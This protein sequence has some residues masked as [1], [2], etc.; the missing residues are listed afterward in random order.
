M[1]GPTA[2][3]VS[4][5]RPSIPCGVRSCQSRSAKLPQ[6]TTGHKIASARR[7]NF[8]CDE[9]LSKHSATACPLPGQE[10]LST[11]HL[12]FSNPNGNATGVDNIMRSAMSFNR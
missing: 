3:R 8:S 10:C 4:K 11:N 6:P 7:G 5:D 2:L 12:I 9:V 1:A